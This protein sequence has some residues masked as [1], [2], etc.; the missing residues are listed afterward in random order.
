MR[1]LLR[2][3]AVRCRRVV[4]AQHYCKANDFSLIY[5][6]FAAGVCIVL[7][8][9]L[10][11]TKEPPIEEQTIGLSGSPGEKVYNSDFD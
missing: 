3:R 6:P 5:S 2:A 7:T 1:A 8:P 9:T 4:A 10:G 11:R